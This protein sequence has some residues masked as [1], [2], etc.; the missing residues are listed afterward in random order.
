MNSMKKK[1]TQD[2]C[3]EC[4]FAEWEIGSWPLCKGRPEDHASARVRWAQD[5]APIVIFKAPDGRVRVPGKGA[6]K[7][8]KGYERVELRTRREVDA[9]TREYGASE[10]MRAERGRILDQHLYE[11]DFGRNRA[12]VQQI[13]EGADPVVR[14]YIDTVIREM[15]RRDRARKNYDPGVYFEVMENWK[16]NL[17]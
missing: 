3:P 8:P 14:E 12:E 10:A 1:T 13:R 7:A 9:F 2:A 15:D 4:G 16:G 11:R 17:D 6:A 5:F